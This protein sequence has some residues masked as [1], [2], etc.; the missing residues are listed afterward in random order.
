MI[1][2]LLLCV[3]EREKERERDIC[4]KKEKQIEKWRES[5][6]QRVLHCIPERAIVPLRAKRV[7]EVANLT[8]RKNPPAPVYGVKEFVCLSVLFRPDLDSVFRLKPNF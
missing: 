3:C 6:S 5:E 8:E 1:Q 4:R 2:T 7:R